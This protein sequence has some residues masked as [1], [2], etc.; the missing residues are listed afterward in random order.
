MKKLIFVTSIL[1]VFSFITTEAQDEWTQSSIELRASFWGQSD[2]ASTTVRVGGPEI[3]AAA[4]SFGGKIEYLYHIN[5]YWGF[6]VSAG[7]LTGDASVRIS[8]GE[9]DTDANVIVPLLFTG[10]FYPLGFDN[11]IPLKPYLKCGV[12]LFLGTQSSETVAGTVTIDTRTESTVGGFLGLGGDFVVT[13]FFKLN[14]EGGYNIVGEYSEPIGG[15]K[16]YSGPEFSIGL[17]FMF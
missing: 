8:G 2:D 9:V 10:R 16:D 7:M 6:G 3:D 14:A 17:G 1:L 15:R 12:G 4:N 11:L 13:S 5:P